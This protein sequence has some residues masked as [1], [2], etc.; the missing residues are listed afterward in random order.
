[1]SKRYTLQRMWESFSIYLKLPVLFLT[2][3]LVAT[4]YFS[5]YGYRSTIRLLIHSVD[6][7]L[8]LCAETLDVM[9]PPDYIDRAVLPDG[10]S[11]EEH[12]RLQ[13][14]IAHITREGEL[15]DLYA[16]IR[17]ENGFH[18]VIG[19]FGPFFEDYV[20]DWDSL[21]ATEKD[22]ETRYDDDFD[23]YGPSRSIVMRR[24]SPGG[25]QYFIGADVALPEIEQLR[26]RQLRHFIITGIVS[27]FLVGAISYS[28]VRLITNPLKR[29]S[30]ITEATTKGGF[31]GIA[32]F[33]DNL[34]PLTNRPADEVRLLA[35]NFRSM[36]IEL[37]E[38]ISR[39]TDTVAAK[40]RVESEMRIAGDIQQGL[41]T[42][43][44]PS[45]PDFAIWGAMHPAKSVGGDFYDFFMLDDRR[46][47]FVIGDVSGKGVSAAVFMATAL[48]LFRACAHD[49][50]A[51]MDRH[52]DRF[53]S[54][55]MRRVDV[56]LSSHNESL[57]FVT[58][59]M[60]VLDV[61]TGEVSLTNSGH[62]PP[63]RLPAEG[64]GSYVELPPCMLLGA[65][66]DVEFEP[67][68]LRLRRGEALVLYTDG[69]TE[70]IA[71]NGEFFGEDRLRETLLETRR[72]SSK[73]VVESLFD[74]VIDFSKGCELA[75]DI[76]AVCL[77]WK[78]A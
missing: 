31:S 78:N 47:C 23:S 20:D 55:V 75:D 1:M 37:A 32:D 46:L 68:H 66:M 26:S 42:R 10:I 22:G 43:T 36:Q 33:D 45:S 19:S 59:V 2:T 12:H 40:E 11:P 77:R 51:E 72:E 67:T 53:I 49:A 58:A 24:T 69:V 41:L 9:L 44:P 8:L 21:E 29:L 76:T 62:N 25:R 39:L 65:G 18:E 13:E 16:L 52:M 63:V 64:E 73:A 70:A 15:A 50:A 61:S 74:A 28:I 3:L 48:T 71:K 6:T 4:M 35:K 56:A 17:D 30:D 5:W 14:S 38:H 60:G 54:D 34:L 7:R 27:F 57:M